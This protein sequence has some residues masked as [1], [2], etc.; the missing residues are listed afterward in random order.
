MFFIISVLQMNTIS[1]FK[2]KW[3]LH[4][5]VTDDVDIDNINSAYKLRVITHLYSNEAHIF[6]FVVKFFHQSN[7]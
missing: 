4:F 6:Q 3:R 7:L 2:L 5:A 1:L